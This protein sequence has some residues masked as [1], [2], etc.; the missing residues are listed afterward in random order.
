[1]ELASRSG[2]RWGEEFQLTAYD[3]HLGG[4]CRADQPRVKK[5]KKAKK[6]KKQK[7][8]PHIHVDWQ[9]DPGANADD[10]NGRRCLPKG[11]KRRTIVIPKRTFTGYPL[12][13]ELAERVGAVL[14]EQ[15]AGT[16][17]E[18]LLF[19]AARGGL[20]W[21][22]SFESD[23]LLP[24]MDRAGWPL[25]RWTEVRAVWSEQTRAYTREERKRTMARLPW[26]STRHR[27]ARTMI[28][29]F[30]MKPGELMAVGGWENIATVENRYYKS[31]KEHEESALDRVER[32]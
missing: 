12:R 6:G 32:G 2:P 22:T 3:L 13:A 31:G 14:E 28:D 4:C 15:A 16:N 1:V 7:F 27:F 8:R 24:A 19:P 20:Q 11:G 5:A 26:H 21:Y 25:E 10:P 23:L 9:I 17:L 29:R 30:E 18:A